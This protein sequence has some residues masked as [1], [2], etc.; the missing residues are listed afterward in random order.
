MRHHWWIVLVLVA[1]VVSATPTRAEVVDIAPP[2]A[3]ARAER[4][5]LLEPAE[6]AKISQL[7]R[8]V[9]HFVAS[10]VSPDDA[11]VLVVYVSPNTDPDGPPV[12]P[13]FAFLNIQDGSQV[14]LP[15]F[16]DRL[17][18]LTN[19]AWRDARTA[20][21]VGLNEN[22]V[23]A[24]ITL[25]RLT[26]QANSAPI[27]QNL[28][29]FPLSLAPDGTRLL[30]VRV[31]GEEDPPSLRS[32]F[33][34][35]VQLRP[36][37]PALLRDMLPRAWQDPPEN[38]L[39]ASSDE[40]KLSLFD[41]RTG[42]L[43]DLIG[44]PD[45]T[46]LL[47]MPTWSPDGQKLAMVRTEVGEQLRGG[48]SLATLTTQDALGNLP[49][50]G[51]PLLQNNVVDI[52]DLDIDD[53][54]S[55]QLRATDN[56]GTDTFV[57]VSWSTDNN[58]LL[59]RMHRP[60]QLSGRQYPVYTFPESS[61]F[62]FYDVRT[63][64]VVGVFDAPQVSAP[65]AIS[66]T[67]I[68]P[69][70][71]LFSGAA[72]LSMRMY[73]YNRAT[74]EFRELSSRAGAYTQ[75]LP[76]RF[77]RQV[78]FSFSS[79]ENP[80]ELYRI[81]WNGEALA[82]LTY[83]NIETQRQNEIQ[84]NQVSF[85]MSGGAV[86]RGYLIQPAGAPFPPSNAPVVVWQE[87]GPGVPM[88]NRWSTNVENPTT[89]LPNFGIS[90]LFLPLPGREGWGPEFY[91][92]LAE[93]RNYGSIDIDEGAQAVQQMIERGYAAEN[94]VG[95]TG[96]SYGGYFTSQS[97]TRYPELYAAANTQCTLLDMITE[98]QTGFTPFVSYLMGRSPTIDPM[99]F[100]RDSP[101]F[102][103]DVVRTPTLVFH[104]EQDYLPVNIAETFHK[105]IETG[106]APARM[107]RF[108]AEGH[109]LA[110]PEN[111]LLAAQ[112]QIQW[113][114]THL[115]STAEAPAGLPV[116]SRGD[117]PAPPADEPAPPPEEAAPPPEEAAP[118]PTPTPTPLPVRLIQLPGGEAGPTPTPDDAARP[119]ITR[120]GG[121]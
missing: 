90:V 29:G 8:T 46:A 53:I 93:Q 3:P 83:S 23:P 112:E 32:P 48:V 69:G 30:L 78:I 64:R 75:I 113:F 20:V 34:V 118:E 51:N 111:Q 109:G 42:D 9:Q 31:P 70:E 39:A 88:V 66:G 79:F 105:E 37:R 5:P 14:P 63:Q 40:L 61:Y 22:F 67:F 92:A 15:G 96:C 13:R 47:S 117:E 10:P 62:R 101:L 18:P 73:Y 121:D 1:L 16:A 25:D 114:R 36:P 120:D 76:T 110:E 58:T 57:D 11:A 56:N 84:V 119:S 59:T 80:P 4:E 102:E 45:G 99:E 98:W 71:V 17:L 107:L 27:G 12:I 49:P 35:R 77:S 19:I 50:V 43:N 106:G 116:T 52:F 103:S 38:E 100:L 115:G 91:T 41:L 54:Q 7:Q 85:T 28:P 55:T 108:A 81:G 104:G 24:V 2:D 65:N 33:D 72:G 26:G 6:V 97:I 94:Q 87:G 60:A 95:I 44:L 89:L 68:S 74:Q 82:A 21:F 86:R